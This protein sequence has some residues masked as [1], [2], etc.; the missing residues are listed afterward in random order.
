M[1]NQ[2]FG[3]RQLTWDSPNSPGPPGPS[4]A[5]APCRWFGAAVSDATAKSPELPAFPFPA[6]LAK[7][8]LGGGTIREFQVVFFLMRFILGYLINPDSWLLSW[9][10]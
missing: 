8:P 5:M 2:V 10:L 4:G 6:T 1:Q 7:A 3:H 9:L